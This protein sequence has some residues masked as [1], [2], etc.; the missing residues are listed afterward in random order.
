MPVLISSMFDSIILDAFLCLV[1][2]SLCW[3]EGKRARRVE[4]MAERMAGHDS[5][6]NKKVKKKPKVARQALPKVA[7]KSKAKARAVPKAAPKAAP[8]AT[9]RKPHTDQPYGLA[10]KEFA[11][12]LLG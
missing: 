10:K 9:Q 8:K 5:I 11:R 7:A 3:Q 2:C 12:K 6:P 4:L 1:S